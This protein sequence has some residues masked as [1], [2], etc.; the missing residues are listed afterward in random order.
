MAAHTSD[1]TALAENVLTGP[2]TRV[3]PPPAFTLGRAE[4]D[5]EVQEYRKLRRQVFVQQQELFTG[6]DLDELDADPRTVVVVARDGRG[7]IVGGV[8]LSPATDPDI[9]W[10]T[11]SRLVVAPQGQALRGVGSALVR[12]ACVI[13]ESAG[14]LRFD[15]TVQPQNEVLFRRLGWQRVRETS[16]QSRPHV[17]MR[18][19]IERISRLVRGTKAPLA[20]LLDVLQSG[21]NSLGGDGFVGDD[22]APVPGSDVIAASDAILPSM[23]E[24]TPEWAGWCAVLVNVNDLSAMGAT[25]VGLLDSLGAR[26]VSF[27]RRVL[28]GLKDAAD[29]WRVP[30]L[31][32]HT[33]LGVPASLSVTALGRTDRPVAAGGGRSG[34]TVSVTADLGGQWRQGYAGAQWDSTSVRTSDDL[35]AMAGCVAA[36]RPRAAKDISMAGLVGTLGM[37]AEASGTGAEL[38]VAAVPRP[39]AAS[40]GD[41]FTCFPGFGMITTDRPDRTV[42]PAGPAVTASCG[43][44]TDGAGVRLRWPDG[45]LTDVLDVVTG[46]GKA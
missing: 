46:L 33:Q 22:G 20:G 13:A 12:A 3:A 21:D 32:G 5:W 26:D 18:Y 39:D 31:G 44:L 14:V 25:A 19:P 7:E 37:L 15:A 28:T 36:T 24:R 30:V 10:W 2:I 42:A 17:L 40:V 35:A 4:F 1:V 16:V 8:R 38:D 43:R 6:T 23:V 41:W 45:E 27:A 34:D 9:G 29:A 11:G